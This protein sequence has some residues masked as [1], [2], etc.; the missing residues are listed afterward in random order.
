M[1]QLDRLLAA[2]KNSF[3]GEASCAAVCFQR[4]HETPPQNPPAP[5]RRTAPGRASPLSVLVAPEAI[6]AVRFSIAYMTMPVF[7]LMRSPPVC[8]RFAFLIIGTMLLSHSAETPAG[9]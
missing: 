6:R 4:P 1:R 3:A 2:P 9:T 8:H 7:A 5:H